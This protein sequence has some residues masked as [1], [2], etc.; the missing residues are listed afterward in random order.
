[1]KSHSCRK[2][3]SS[4]PYCCLSS[5]LKTICLIIWS[6]VLTSLRLSKS[7]CPSESLQFSVTS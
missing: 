6:T 2:N 7:V 4:Q 5:E 3:A 1:M